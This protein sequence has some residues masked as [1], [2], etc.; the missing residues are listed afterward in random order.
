MGLNSYGPIWKDGILALLMTAQMCAHTGQQDREF[1]RLGDIII[2]PGFQTQNLVGIRILPGQHD[3]RGALTPFL[4]ISRQASRPSIS[5]NSTSRRTM[6]Y[7]AHRA[8][9]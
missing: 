2:G 5:G 6:I 3:D 8:R 1:E 4:R 9:S 7:R